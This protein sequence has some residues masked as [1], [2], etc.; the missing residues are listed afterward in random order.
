[1]KS[2]FMALMLEYETADI[3]LAKCCDK[4]FGLS[5]TKAA[6]KARHQEL[7][8]PC[9]RGGSQKSEWLINAHDL[10]DWLDH[11]KEQARNDHKRLNANAA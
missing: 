11:L 2:T 8:V 10:A 5:Y 1:M 4:Y 6:T 7:P 3:P 9:F